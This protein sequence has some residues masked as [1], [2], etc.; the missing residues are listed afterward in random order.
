MITKIILSM[1]LTPNCTINAEVFDDVDCSDFSKILQMRK[2][3][4]TLVMGN[5][6]FPVQTQTLYSDEKRITEFDSRI[7]PKQ[8]GMARKLLKENNLSEQEFCLQHG[9]EK[10]EAM[11]KKDARDAI[12]EL[13]DSKKTNH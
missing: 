13:I 3:L 2:A 9:V 11:P 5:A 7:S 4:K 12:G 1:A 6:D 10:L 8:I